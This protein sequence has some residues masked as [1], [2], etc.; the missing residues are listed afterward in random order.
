MATIRD[1]KKE[2]NYL[3][4][5][6]VTEAYVR[7]IL[8]NNIKEEDFTKVITDAIEVH[9][10]SITKINHP[11]NKHDP[12]KVKAYYREIRDEMDTKFAGLV[13]AVNSLK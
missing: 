1:L 5:E 6:V 4:S 9:N 11:D 10:D 8:F 2:L 13:E 3:T 12:K 7:K